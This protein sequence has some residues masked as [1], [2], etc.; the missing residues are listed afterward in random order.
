[1]RPRKTILLV[2]AD[3]EQAGELRYVLEMRGYRV[4]CRSREMRGYRVL[5]AHDADSALALHGLG[6]VDMVLGVADGME[7]EWPALAELL[8]AR[9]P[10]MPL[11]VVSRLKLASARAWIAPCADAVYCWQGAMAELLEWIYLRIQRKRG[12]RK[13]ALVAAVPAMAGD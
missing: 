1:M 3:E 12:P 5:V 13:I 10:E 2:N 4:P 6:V 8:K 7:R 11:L 9:T